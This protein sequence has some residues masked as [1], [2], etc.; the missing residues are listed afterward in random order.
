MPP[1]SCGRRPPRDR[2]PTTTPPQPSG[3]ASSTSY[4]KRRTTNPQTLRRSR[5]PGPPRRG[6]ST[7]SHPCRARRRHRRSARAAE[8]ASD[9][10][11]RRDVSA[12][13]VA[14]THSDM[15]QGGAS[16][17]S[18]DDGRAIDQNPDSATAPAAGLSHPRPEPSSGP[19]SDGA[20]IGHDRAGRDP[21]DPAG[22][23]YGA[24]APRTMTLDAGPRPPPLR[25]TLT[26][27]WTGPRSVHHRRQSCQSLTIQS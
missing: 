4:R 6:H 19:R 26:A 11:P 21:P 25:P 15:C 5:R 9:A 1:T 24:I 13:S 3:G 20:Q 22:P 17:R 10:E 8:P 12:G 27:R 18:P 7:S 23:G 16:R 2:Y 14:E